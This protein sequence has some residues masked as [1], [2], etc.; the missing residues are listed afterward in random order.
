MLIISNQDINLLEITYDSESLELWDVGLVS[1]YLHDVINDVALEILKQQ[2]DIKFNNES[3]SAFGITYMPKVVKT[4]IKKV[5]Q[6]SITYLIE[7]ALD[8]AN[9]FVENQPYIG[10]LLI[11]IQ[12]SLMVHFADLNNKH[13]NKKTNIGTNQKSPIPANTKTARRIQVKTNKLFFELNKN[14][15]SF[16]LTL[17]YKDK[18]ITFE[19]NNKL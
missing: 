18:E 8:T 7:L 19:K 12:A 6:G 11:S 5:S 15:E 1:K 9:T 4:E 3:Y 10:N 17:R 2:N 14:K 13:V 16:N